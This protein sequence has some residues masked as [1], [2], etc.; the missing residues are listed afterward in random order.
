MQSVVDWTIDER[1]D[2]RVIDATDIVAQE[3]H[4]TKI[5]RRVIAWFTSHRSDQL[6]LLPLRL[7]F[8]FGHFYIP[9]PSP[10]RRLDRGLSA[11]LAGDLWSSLR[12]LLH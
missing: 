4:K 9:I 5:S 8:G 12:G 7:V 10:V 6:S 1:T 11:V 3:S 2:G